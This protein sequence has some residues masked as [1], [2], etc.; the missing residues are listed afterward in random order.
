[1]DHKLDGRGGPDDDVLNRWEE[2]VSSLKNLQSLT[3]EACYAVDALFLRHLPQ[4]L[5]HLEIVHCWNLTTDD[6]MDFLGT[7]G[8]DLVTLTLR[9]NQSLDLRF[10][11]RLRDTCPKL[12][13]L[14]VNMMFYKDP[15]SNRAEPWFTAALE[16]GEVPAWPSSLRHLELLHVRPWT[17][18]AALMF[19]ESLVNQARDLPNLRYL[20]IKSMLDID[21]RKRAVMRSEWLS[22][23]E[24]VFLRRPKPPRPVFSLEPLRKAK[25]QAEAEAQAQ[26]EMEG[27]VSSRKRAGPSEPTRRSRRVSDLYSDSCPSSASSFALRRPNYAEPPSDV[28]DDS[29]MDDGDDDSDVEMS[30]APSS[31]G[32]TGDCFV[33]GMCSRVEFTMENHKLAEVQFDMDDFMDAGD[34]DSA[35]SDPDFST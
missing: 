22:R 34:A 30:E 29:D 3:L 24:T 27:G 26:A 32:P 28:E 23:L 35:L 31:A 33:Q 5:K 18:D 11:T 4:K 10:L 9:H 14:V 19:L 20:V 12:E 15:D 6:F 1:M 17:V 2:V 16:E 7:H 25:A 8:R 21:W 13:E